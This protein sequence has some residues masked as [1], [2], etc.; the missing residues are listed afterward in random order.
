MY[1]RDMVPGKTYRGTADGPLELYGVAFTVLATA[2]FG[3]RGCVPK[4]DAGD[5]SVVLIHVQYDA[6]GYPFP[7]SQAFA[8]GDWVIELATDGSNPYLCTVCFE[9]I[10]SFDPDMGD[11]VTW[12]QGTCFGCKRTERTV[13]AL[14][15]DAFEAY[16]KYNLR[17]YVAQH[18]HPA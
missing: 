9:E 16:K 13:F 14:D 17:G 7:E 10:Y 5:T 11:P 18:H 12:K 15:D 3:T 8:P 4:D 2:S 6:W 1:A